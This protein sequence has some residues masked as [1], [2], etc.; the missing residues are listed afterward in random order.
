MSSLTDGSEDVNDFLQAIKGLGEKRDEEDALRNKKLEEEILQGRKERQARRAERARSIS[1]TKSSP[2]NTPTAS[3]TSA[4]KHSSLSGADS[5]AIEP[6]QSSQHRHDTDTEGALDPLFGLS[7]SPQT[8][9]TKETNFTLE[10]DGESTSRGTSRISSGKA[11]PSSAMPPR[12]QPLSWQRRP[13][14]QASDRPRSRPLS[15]VA[16]ENAARS[17]RATPEPSPPFCE[18]TPSREQIAQSLASKDPA[19]FRQ[20]ADK[21]ANSPAYRRNQVEDEYRAEHESNPARVQIPDMPREMSM[22]KP[23][24]DTPDCSASASP[25]RANSGF[26]QGGSR[27]SALGSSVPLTSAQRFDPPTIDSLTEARSL[28]MS[29][30]QGRISP[31]R[32]D[33]PS[34]PTKGMGGFVQSAMMKRSDSVSKRWSVQSPPGLQRGNSVASNRS[35]QDFSN[36]AGVVS[37]PG[38]SRPNSRGR[39]NYPLPLSRPTSS[40][41]ND[42]ITQDGRPGTSSS[43]G[44]ILTMSTDTEG[45]VRPGLPAS[46][47]QTPKNDVGGEDTP[48]V[49]K[50]QT[51]TTPP[52]SPSKAMDP[53]RW[54]PTKASWLESALKRPD[55][56]KPKTPAPTPQQPSWMAEINKA[57]SN[58]GSVD[59]GRSTGGAPKHDVSIGGL[60]RSPPMGGDG[61]TTAIRG[62]SI[63][64]SS[65]GTPIKKL[66]SDAA[67]K[68][69]LP[70]MEPPR[71]TSP[72]PSTSITTPMS[73]RKPSPAGKDLHP[74]ISPKPTSAATF[75]PLNKAKPDTPVKNDF[76]ANLKPRQP[77]STV[78]K[79]EP[80][81]KNVFGQLRRTK[82]QNYV[83]PDELKSKITRGKAA[84]N[85]T[86][87]PKK[88]EHVDEFKVAILKKK[89]D[90]KKAQSEGKGVTKAD[91]TASKTSEIPEALAKR[92]ALGRK[93]SIVLTSSETPASPSA[94]RDG[95]KFTPS[96]HSS[97]PSPVQGK[98][99]IGGKLAGRFNPALA[100]LLARGPPSTPSETSRSSSPNVPQR[101]ASTST[102]A[103]VESSE[104]GPQLTHMTKGRAR[105]P[106]RKA[107]SAAP[108]AGK[109]DESSAEQQLPE[110]TWSPLQ[111]VENEMKLVPSPVIPSTS[112]KA[113]LP[114]PIITSSANL[115]KTVSNIPSTPKS[116]TEKIFSPKVPSP[117]KLDMKRRSQFLQESPDKS[118]KGAAVSDSKTVSSQSET[119]TAPEI[120]TKSDVVEPE[121]VP[122]PIARVKPETPVKSPSLKSSSPNS[123]HIVDSSETAKLRPSPLSPSKMPMN[124]LNKSNS[125]S[126]SPLVEQSTATSPEKVR[127]AP[128]SLQ[129]KSIDLLASP[130][131]PVLQSSSVGMFSPK[132]Q[133]PEP[134]SSVRN[135]AARWDQPS[136]SQASQQPRARSPI[137]LQTHDDEKSAIVGAGLQSPSPTKPMISSTRTVRSVRPLPEPSAKGPASPYKAYSPGKKASEAS[138]MITEF[139]GANQTPADYITDT[140]EILA[141]RPDKY[142]TVRTLTSELYQLSGDGKKKPVPSHQERLLFEGNMYVCVHTFENFS[143]RKVTEVYFWVGDEV[144]QAV[145][146][147]ADIY[148]QREAKTAS[149]ELIKIR[150]GKETPALI[151]ALGGIIII[152][153]GTSNKYDS[154]SPNILC[155]RKYLG[156]ITFDEVDYSPTS[157]CSGFPYLISTSASKCYLWKGQGSGVEEL[158]CAR[159]IGMDFG[160]M[161]DIEEIEEGKEPV[162]LLQTFGNEATIPQSAN[163][164]KMKPNYDRYCGRLFCAN[165]TAK[166]QVVEIAPFCQSDVSPENIYILD[167]FFEMYIIVGSKAQSQYVAFHHALTFAQEYSILAAGME[168]RPHVPITTVVLGGIPRDMKS[169]FRKWRDGLALTVMP[170]QSSGLR[171]GKSLRVI[172]LNAA[173]EATRR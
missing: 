5:P 170:E 4:I 173:L 34:S 112:R 29:P 164:W 127:P 23:S 163:H 166:S 118:S 72:R 167:A 74:N 12:N 89:D 104:P 81:F 159:L 120:I 143:G 39:D 119:S 117:S 16:T 126:Q 18:P 43:M 148:A 42:T 146:E 36:P 8:S 95:L 169:V 57:K 9:T 59:L 67:A 144:L 94:T 152:R 27:V 15:V 54:S 56:P 151:Q 76:R 52:S 40:H 77:S 25:F 61:K 49:K 106:R 46:H 1:P 105:G 108:S 101:T 75:P 35:T 97:T 78:S 66:E 165:P 116:D 48:K 99:N 88:I 157:L 140:T 111:P 162:L 161:G 90:F 103:T 64:T 22:E 62:C 115:F 58:K 31:E 142:A 92:Q 3:I 109:A 19:W 154:L 71:V 98:E 137:K 110:K 121:S 158:G 79:G 6:P 47:S 2:A 55:S 136:E 145:A 37:P 93:D 60:M 17:P 102:S 26:Q 7:A 13:N 100:G 68:D 50:T 24:T 28:A 41:S 82:T 150:Q 153:R 172:P 65:V 114:L 11:S 131:T 14:S 124:T 139:F 129:K 141:A 138:S 33:R 70:K 135:A 85:T 149:G 30:A 73:D 10:G 156:Q 63:V 21:G 171:R 84:L 69:P 96:K 80:E 133:A 123:D 168:D 134:S 87:G 83:A 107:P 160:V 86:G 130:R 32:L 53:R 125:S 122:T 128:L 132:F 20:T 155:A 51:E 113:T 44:S 147:D 91:P 38:I 45:F